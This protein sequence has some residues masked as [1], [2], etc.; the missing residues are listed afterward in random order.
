[1]NVVCFDHRISIDLNYA[2][3]AWSIESLR[4]NAESI[5]LSDFSC[6][7]IYSERL[8]LDVNWMMYKDERI[9][10]TLDNNKIL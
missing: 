6:V 10:K 8:S 7:L 9:K 3:I 2:V 5:S 1:M 4:G